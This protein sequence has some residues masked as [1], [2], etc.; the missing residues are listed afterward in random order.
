MITQ[1]DALELFEYRDGSLY[2]KSSPNNNV[3]VGSVVGCPNKTGAVR[4][5]IRGKWYLV[6]RII[7]LMFYGYA[8]QCIDH[9]NRDRSDNHIEN[10]R[11]ATLSQN[12][13][14]RVAQRN[15]TSGIKNVSWNVAMKKWGVSLQVNKKLMRFGF[16]EDL[17]LA[18]LVAVEAREK[19]HKLFV[20]HS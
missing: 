6:H 12:Q 10:L 18:S 9:I 19:Y 20:N 5:N 16:F 1:A 11:E 8:P 13:Y 2:W 15:N 4:T 3:P 7:F 14:N 17:E